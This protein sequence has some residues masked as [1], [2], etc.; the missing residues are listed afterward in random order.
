MHMADALVSP[1]IGGVMMAASAGAMVYSVAR[2]K[3]DGPGEKKIPVMGV[4]GAFVFAAQM[5]N[6]TIPGTGSSG[7][8]GGGM[9]LAAMLGGPPAYVVMAV[10]L[11]IQAFFFGDGGILALGANIWN[12]G[13]YT[14]FVVFPLI[15]KKIMRKGITNKRIFVASIVSV[16]AALQM[17]AF[18]V[19]LETLASGVTDLP[20]ALF[21]GLMQPIHLA[22]GAVEGVVTAAVLCYVH[23]ARPELLESAVRGRPLAGNLKLKRVVAVLAVAAV[24]A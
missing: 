13:F 4:V 8:I 1:A 15:Y 2:M 9:L 5:I 12:L 24:I 20:F 23:R 6:F 14:C 10:V 16:V 19:V 7:H 3:K 11:A 18:S 17:G 21:A 22:I